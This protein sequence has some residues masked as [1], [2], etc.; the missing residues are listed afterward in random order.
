MVTA[1]E[2]SRKSRPGD[3]LGHERLS[4]TAGRRA[5]RG[6]IIS[7]TSN[8]PSGAGLR[9]TRKWSGNAIST[10]LDRMAQDRERHREYRTH[11]QSAQRDAAAAPREAL[12]ARSR[13]GLV[14]QC[15]AYACPV[16]AH[17][18]APRRPTSN[19][20]ASSNPQLTGHISP[21][22]PCTRMRTL[23]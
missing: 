15:S 21:C 16:H 9:Q 18:A 2:H 1:G 23:R 13:R 5:R 3:L 12:R 14:D 11:A 6:S 10:A 22:T 7:R 20:P 19:Q 4:A 17:A 8:D